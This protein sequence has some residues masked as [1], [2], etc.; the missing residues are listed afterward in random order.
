M[1][2][3]STLFLAVSIMIIMVGMG[4]GLTIQDF[5][6]IADNRKPVI[7]GLFNQIVLLPLVGFGLCLVF[8]PE[9]FIAIGL[10]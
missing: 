2:Q 6:R 4:L 3:A 7:I 5:K 8:K 10:L 9:P 1:D